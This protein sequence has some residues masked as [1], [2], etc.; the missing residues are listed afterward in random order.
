MVKR[1]V[2]KRYWGM[3]RRISHDFNQ[4]GLSGRE[5]F[6]QCLPQ[7]TW[8]GNGN[9][10]TT[11]CPRNSRV[12]HRRKM[13][14]RSVV[15]ELHGLGIFLITQDAVIENNDNDGDVAA[16]HGFDFRPAM[17]K[18]AISHQSNDRIAWTGDL[19]TNG[20]RQSP[21]KPGQSARREKPLARALT[22]KL[23]DEP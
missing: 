14:G 6:V 2:K 3:R 22:A 19:G 18:A 23:T 5:C 13:A 1:A 11:A 17:G 20:Q 12:V 8:L 9:A 15:A 7:V 4:P 21:I 10:G 16:N